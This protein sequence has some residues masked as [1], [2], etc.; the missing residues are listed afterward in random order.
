MLHSR[1]ARIWY[2]LNYVQARPEFNHRLASAVGT[3]AVTFNAEDKLFEK[4]ITKENNDMQKPRA[5]I[6][7][8]MTNLGCVRVPGIGSAPL[9]KSKTIETR[10]NYPNAPIV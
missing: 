4:K 1:S 3:N 9:P 10:V 7:I 5:R 8:A 2:D 6:L